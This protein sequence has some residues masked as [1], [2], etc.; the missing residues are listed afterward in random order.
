VRTVHCDRFG[1]PWRC[2]AGSRSS[3]RRRRGHDLGFSVGLA[4]GYA[5]L[6]QVGIAG[7]VE[8]TAIGTVTN[9]AQRLCSVAA[10]SQILVSPRVH[11]AVEEFVVSTPLNDLELKGFARPL[12]AHNIVGLNEA[13]VRA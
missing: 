11:A 8:Y 7:R 9:L 13:R 12:T 10:D 4:Q 6:G 5:T 2:A 3:P 1:W